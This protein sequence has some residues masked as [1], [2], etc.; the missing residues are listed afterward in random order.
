[1]HKLDGVQSGSKELEGRYNWRGSPYHI[2]IHALQ[3]GTSFEYGVYN[4]LFWIFHT[5]ME[6]PSAKHV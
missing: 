6:Y 1:M 5:Q 4:N 3:T 2:I